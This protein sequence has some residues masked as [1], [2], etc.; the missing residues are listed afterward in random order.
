MTTLTSRGAA[1][2]VTGGVF[3]T[4]VRTGEYMRDLG[5]PAT[6]VRAPALR[7]ADGARLSAAAVAGGVPDRGARLRGVA[8]RARPRG[9]RLPALGAGAGLWAVGH[10]PGGH[11]RPSRP[12]PRAPRLAPP[13]AAD[14]LRRDPRRAARPSRR[15]PRAPRLAAAVLVVPPA[16]PAGR[17]ARALR[18]DVGL[19]ARVRA[20]S[21]PAGA[22]PLFPGAPDGGLARAPD[23]LALVLPGA[24]P[25]AAPAGLGG[26]VRQG[27]GRA[28]ANLD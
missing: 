13:P 17:E 20:R 18:H 1:R 25:A 12:G 24:P 21:P 22:Q 10:R 15:R 28:G 19:A 26:P 9:E 3:G 8:A 27:G 16:G 11:N 7:A 6:V 14:A 2:A 23:P 5:L 4:N